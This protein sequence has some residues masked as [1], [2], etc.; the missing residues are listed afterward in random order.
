MHDDIHTHTLWNRWAA[1]IKTD[2]SKF[3]FDSFDL[4][5][6]TVFVFLRE[7]CVHVGHHLNPSRIECNAMQFHMECVCVDNEKWL[8]ETFKMYK[9]T[10][11]D[12]DNCSARVFVWVPFDNLFW[13]PFFCLIIVFRNSNV[14]HNNNNRVV[15]VGIVKLNLCTVSECNK[16]VQVRCCFSSS[17]SWNAMQKSVPTHYFICFSFPSLHHCMYLALRC[18]C[19]CSLVFIGTHI[20]FEWKATRNKTVWLVLSFAI[21]LCAALTEP[22]LCCSCKIDMAYL[23]MWDVKTGEK[24]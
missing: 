6:N 19:C 18:C 23:S 15:L 7:R 22:Y 20:Y 17:S 21:S 11:T 9:N 14:T 16:S 24:C 3:L 10:Y 8:D 5:S 13:G 1:P 2:R 12:W 4:K